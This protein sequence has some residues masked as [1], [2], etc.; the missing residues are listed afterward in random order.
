[1]EIEL[2]IIW[3]LVDIIPIDLMVG[4]GGPNGTQGGGDGGPLIILMEVVQIVLQ[5]FLRQCRHD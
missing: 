3:V 1:M 2:Q 5:N 4:Y